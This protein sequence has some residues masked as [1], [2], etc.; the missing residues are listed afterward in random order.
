ME[1]LSRQHWSDPFTDTV[2]DTDMTRQSDNV[3]IGN[4]LWQELNYVHV[5]TWLG[6]NKRRYSEE[7]IHYGK[8]MNSIPCV[9]MHQTNVS[10]LN[11]DISYWPVQI[12]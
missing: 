12:S 4:G 7:K 10:L 6:Q 5:C 3:T 9:S 1:R 2:T 11:L 8:L